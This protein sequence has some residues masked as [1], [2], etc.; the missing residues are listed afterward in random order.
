[1]GSPTPMNGPLFDPD[2][3]PDPE[4][5]PKPP[6]EPKLAEVDEVPVVP[7]ALELESLELV[8]EA[9]TPVPVDP[10]VFDPKAVLPLVP[11]EDMLDAVPSPELAIPASG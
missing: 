8:V 11:V 6:P 1:L 10:G 3:K 2:P 9:P 5:E 4:P 7:N